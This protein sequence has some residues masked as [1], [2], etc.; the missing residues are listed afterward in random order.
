MNDG[1]DLANRIAAGLGVPVGAD[2]S[3]LVAVC[4]ALEAYHDLFSL[5]NREIF[6]HPG[7]MVN[8]PYAGAPA[9][10]VERIYNEA[11]KVLNPTTTARELH[12]S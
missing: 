10:E 3:E 4:A 8:N 1:T 2:I 6:P 12:Q 11:A 9:A 7:C 5:E